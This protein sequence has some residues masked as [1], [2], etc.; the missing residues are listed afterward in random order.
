MEYQSGSK[1]SP[2]TVADR[3]NKIASYL[4][5]CAARGF[6]IEEVMDEAA[7]NWDRNEMIVIN[8]A[9][10]TYVGKYGDA[11]YAKEIAAKGAGDTGRQR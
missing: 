3:I 1:S 11:E 2:M 9:Y 7:G 6:T 5:W 4:D 10:V 8:H